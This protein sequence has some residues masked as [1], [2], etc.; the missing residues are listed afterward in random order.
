V[1]LKKLQRHYY[2]EVGEKI[3][4]KILK[5]VWNAASN[6]AYITAIELIG[7]EIITDWSIVNKLNSFSKQ[8]IIRCYFSVMNGEM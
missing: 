3:N 6:Q 8:G 5:L 1:I 7:G 2:L 4:G